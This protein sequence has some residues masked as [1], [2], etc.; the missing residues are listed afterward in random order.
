MLSEKFKITLGFILASLIWGS[1]WLAIKIGLESIPPFYAAAFRFSVAVV[2]LFLIITLRGMPLPL[3]IPSIKLY[4]IA[5]LM[6]F[7]VPFAMVY[8]GQQFIPSGLSSLLFAL[9][10]FMVGI[11]SHFLLPNERLNIFK[12]AGIILGFIGIFIIFSQD[13]S[14][15]G[16]FSLYGMIAVITSCIIQALSLVLIKKYGE[17]VDAFHLNTGGMGLSVI[18]LFLFAFLFE[19]FN[20]VHFNIAGVGSVLYLGIIGSVVTFSTYFW[21]LKRV[22]AV[23]LSLLA[24]ITPILAVILGAIILNEK[25]GTHIIQGGALVLVGILTSNGKYI[26]KQIYKK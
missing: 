12:V 1:T 18:I 5:A 8:W 3:D 26:L 6:S 23:Y 19:D 25:L 21:M 20:D 24:F 10:P 22:E 15:S 9:Y 14:W 4:T 7:S 11:F 13:I 17:N 2:V 16:T